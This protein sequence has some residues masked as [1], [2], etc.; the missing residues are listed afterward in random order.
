MEKATDVDI[1]TRGIFVPL[2]TTLE[3]RGRERLG[4]VYV[5]RVPARLASGVDLFRRTN[6]FATACV[7]LVKLLICCSLVRKLVP[8]DGGLDLQHLR[9]VVKLSDLPSHMQT[10]LDT[11]PEMTT[12]STATAQRDLFLIAGP[13]TA[14]TFSELLISL[15][16]ILGEVEL[17]RVD[18]PLLAPTSQKQAS[19]WSS[20]YWPTVYKKSNPFGPHV[21]ILDRAEEEMGTE[22]GR[23]ME[24]ARDVA[25][26]ANDEGCGERIGVVV[27]ERRKGKGR[28]RAVAGDARWKGWRRG[29]DCGNVTAHAVMRAIGMVA[30]GLKARED[31]EAAAAAAAAAARKEAGVIAEETSRDDA[32]VGPGGLAGPVS[33]DEAG[34]LDTDA[35][36][37]QKAADISQ[38]GDNRHHG[39]QVH[40][41]PLDPPKDQIN[42]TNDSCGEADEI[43]NDAPFLFLEKKHYDASGN[44]D[45]YLCHELEIYCTHEPCVMCSM[46]IVHSR[47]GRVVFRR[48]MHHTGGLCADGELGHG[49][50]WRKELNWTLLAWQWERDGGDDGDDGDEEKEVD[51]YLHA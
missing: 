19:H 1:G 27:V 8:D 33:R 45:G 22:V 11:R 49:L 23:Y 35:D 48:R 16:S 18:V 38:A 6:F 15:R 41:E 32:E 21:S 26:N 17:F 36:R 12:S 9:R 24:L 40:L 5:T 46:A 20:K 50:F 34:L 28:V 51:P 2:K 44:E 25:G 30:G 13:T 7:I 4:K 10:R 31:V 47:F 43:F 37:R 39:F 14:I 42:R 3:T 29:E